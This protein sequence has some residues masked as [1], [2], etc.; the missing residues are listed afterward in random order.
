M[1][2]S[3]F[4][5]KAY[6]LRHWWKWQT[7]KQIQQ[8]TSPVQNGPRFS[9]ALDWV[10][11]RVKISPNGEPLLGGCHPATSSSCRCRHEF[12][13]WSTTWSVNVVG[14][15]VTSVSR[16]EI[17]NRSCQKTAVA[18]FTKVPKLTLTQSR[19][20][21]SNNWLKNST[22]GNLTLFVVSIFMPPQIYLGGIIIYP[23]PYAR[24]YVRLS[25]FLS[26]YTTYGYRIC[27]QLISY[28]SASQPDI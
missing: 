23:C 24:T 10:H 18:Y 14:S 9:L 27:T 22:F 2:E 7:R 28:C 1:L 21:G 19:L 20:K 26:H 8:S 13:A 17:R 12:L 25:P 11:S 15:L 5:A 16:T 4:W 6:N 3:G